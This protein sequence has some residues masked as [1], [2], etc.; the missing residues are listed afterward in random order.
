M[1]AAIYA[2]DIGAYAVMSNHCHIVVRIDCSIP[3]MYWQDRISFSVENAYVR[4]RLDDS[5][6]LFPRE[7][8]KS[9]FRVQAVCVH[10][11]PYPR[12]VSAP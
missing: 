9:R 4:H 8:R 7:I 1:L 12:C 11:L 3:C 6:R 2:I 10:A 5:D